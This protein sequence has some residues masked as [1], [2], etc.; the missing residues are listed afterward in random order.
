M[1]AVAR[2]RVGE[3]V[4]LFCGGGRRIDGRI[5]KTGRDFV[6][7]EIVHD[8]IE[9]RRSPK[10]V[11]A[12]ALSKGRKLDE[13]ARK[14]TEIG[15]DE[16]F[17][18][19]SERSVVRPTGRSKERKEGRWQRIVVEASKQSEQPY[20]PIVHGIVPLC[21][22]LAKAPPSAQRLF[23]WE[24]SERSPRTY[25]RSLLERPTEVWMA[26]GPEGGW[27]DSEVRRVREHRFIDLSLGRSILRTETAAIVAL[28]LIRYEWG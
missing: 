10:I 15:V 11:L 25:L 21:D 8:W 5:L 23:F 16:L 18:V 13:V 12:Q 14:A 26:I 3:I 28:S 20:I 17:F 4:P 24:R 7:I 9:S 2:H 19:A 1:V 27:T 6:E 22:F